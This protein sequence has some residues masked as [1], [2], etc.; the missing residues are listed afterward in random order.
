M[1]YSKQYRTNTS[2]CEE[3]YHSSLDNTTQT[4]LEVINVQVEKLK[5]NM[6]SYKLCSHIKNINK[7]RVDFSSITNV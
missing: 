6:L 4:N 2:W 7:Q 1:I 5:E 3:V